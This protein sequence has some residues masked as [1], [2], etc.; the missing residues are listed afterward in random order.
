[1]PT[2]SV[3]KK[4]LES[5]LQASLSLEELKK[6]LLLVKGEIKAVDEDELR[7]ELADTNRPDLLSVEGI[8]RQL[9]RQKTE[10][11]KQETGISGSPR[12]SPRSG[13]I[14]V[15]SELKNIRPYIGGFL[16][17]G[18]PIKEST[19]LALIETQ[20]KLADIF[21][22]RRKDIAI[23][24][25]NAK[26]IKFPVCYRA[27][28]PESRKFIPLSGEPQGFDCELNLR[29]IL[30]QHPKGKEY[31]Y[32]LSDCQKFPFL[33]DEKGN[34]LSFPPIINSKLIGEVKVGL[35]EIFCEVTGVNL[36]QLLLVVNILA[37]N[38]K[39]RGFKIY[40]CLVK[41]PYT[42]DFGKEVLTPC[43]FEDVL[44]VHPNEFEKLLGLKLQKEEIKKHLE[45]MGYFVE[46]EKD[47]LKIIPPL[48]RRDVMH[49]VDVIEDFAISRG[50]DS[51]SPVPLKE[52]TIGKPCKIE[53]I[54]HKT[55]EIMLGCGF[56]E[57]M[58]NVLTSKESF[59]SNMRL[60]YEDTIELENPISESYAI[61]RDSI[62][63]SLLQVE[64]QSSKATYPHRIFELGEVVIKGDSP[65]TLIKLAA[66][67]AHSTANFSELHSFLDTLAYYLSFS[68]QL[69]KI[70]HPSFIKGR[71]G[72]IVVDNKEVGILG[73]IHPEVL[74][75]FKIKYP[76]SAFEFSLSL[77]FKE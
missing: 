44:L 66:I 77:L 42:T 28:K 68:C 43:Q 61:L 65:K 23:G 67:I 59:I 63:P 51:F 25:Y 41:Y 9:R 21:G 17:T 49:P 55:R 3:S 27:V 72:S 52:F 32:I 2:I 14:I 29:E 12:P 73:E 70:D 16:A 4:D 26:K 64:A 71:V 39:D 34:A 35:E 7:I 33:E 62:I 5:L 75:N 24:V 13:E 57:I 18:V 74:G 58:S 37:E 36:A 46:T 15:D 38:F 54:L 69:K 40:P 60:P 8:A 31:G 47:K 76:V 30:T 10:D 1:M 22:K 20:E 11:R 19:L 48:Y 45:Q 6:S 53:R 50:Y 56:V